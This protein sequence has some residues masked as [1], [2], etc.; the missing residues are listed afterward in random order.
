MTVYLGLGSNLG[1][2]MD[3]LNRAVRL[4]DEIEGASVRRVSPVYETAPVGGPPQGAYL[5]AAVEVAAAIEPR[6]LLRLCKEIESR[7]GR[8]PSGPWGPRTIDIDILLAGE[9]VFAEP[10]LTVPHPRMAERGFVL[11][12]LADIA[13]G[14]IHPVLGVTVAELRDRVGSAGVRRREDLMLSIETT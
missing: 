14:A 5:N 6:E 1:D 7:L 2:R 11:Y 8:T 12:P 3:N 10:G 4:I 13:P 9:A